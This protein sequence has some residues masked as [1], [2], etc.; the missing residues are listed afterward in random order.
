MG[1][2]H[3]IEQ[4]ID[5]AWRG[6]D[7]REELLKSTFRGVTMAKIVNPAPGIDRKT[8]EE[9]ANIAEFRAREAEAIVRRLAAEIQIREL[10]QK[11]R[12]VSGVATK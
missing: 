3:V 2:E 4:S 9:R 11:S 10:T 12:E 7:S 5:E 1:A 6:K 8:W